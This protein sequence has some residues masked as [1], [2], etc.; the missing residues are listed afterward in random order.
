ME[1][2]CSKGEHGAELGAEV[3]SEPLLRHELVIYYIYYVIPEQTKGMITLV[4]KMKTKA[5]EH[6]IYFALS[7]IND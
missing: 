1:V 4:M 7:L 3:S 2:L 6:I 5:N